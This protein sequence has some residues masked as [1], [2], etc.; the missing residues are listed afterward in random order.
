MCQTKVD[1]AVCLQ[2]RDCN[3]KRVLIQLCD[4]WTE[5]DGC[6]PSVKRIAGRCVLSDRTVQRALGKLEATG[7]IRR[8][9]P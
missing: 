5:K 1:W 8:I 4:A 6:Y 7:R 2:I 3:V 9:L